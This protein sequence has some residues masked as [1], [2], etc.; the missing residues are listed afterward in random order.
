MS[1]KIKK[2]IYFE[3][4]IIDNDIIIISTCKNTI[5]MRHRIMLQCIHAFKVIKC[6]KIPLENNAAIDILLIK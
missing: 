4:P 6:T 2:A 3:S 5:G 1:F